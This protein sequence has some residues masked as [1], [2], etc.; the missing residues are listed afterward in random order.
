MPSWNSLESTM[1]SFSAFSRC[2]ASSAAPNYAASILVSSI[3]SR[4]G[5]WPAA[6]WLVD[7][8]PCRCEDGMLS[9]V[10]A[11]LSVAKF[12]DLMCLLLEV[13]GAPS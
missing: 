7:R 10:L 5:T 1:D 2:P 12:P 4:S 3:I 9:I 8:L 13:E 11:C 6:V